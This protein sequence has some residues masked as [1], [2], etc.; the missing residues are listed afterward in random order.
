MIGRLIGIASYRIGI[1]G[2]FQA[3]EIGI[4]AALFLP[5]SDAKTI[6]EYTERY[7]NNFVT[8]CHLHRNL[9]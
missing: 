6:L 3:S 2:F 1:S 5:D 4:G 8:Q 7:K 9:Y